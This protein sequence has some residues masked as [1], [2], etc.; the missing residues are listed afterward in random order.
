MFLKYNKW[1]LLWALIIFVLCVIPGKDIPHVT[2]LELLSFDKLVHAGI[3]FGL[4]SLT[5]RGF[6]LQTNFTRLQQSARSIAFVICVIYGG[7]L[8]VI[9]GAFCQGRTASV[10]DF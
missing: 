2:F 3:F 10:Y 6:L 7:S 8:E 5:I 4:I 9:Q 1:A